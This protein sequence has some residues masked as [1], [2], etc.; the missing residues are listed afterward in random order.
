[1]NQD[2]EQA[3][4]IPQAEDIL[5]RLHSIDVNQFDIV[6]VT[7]ELKGN[8]Q[9]ISILTIPVTTILLGLFTLAGVLLFDSI[10]G[11][12][13]VAAGLLFFAGRILDQYEQQYRIRARHE[14][15]NRIQATEDEFGLIPHFK[16]FLPTKYRH[17]WQSLKKGN[18]MYV[19]QYIQALV[20]LQHKLDHEQFTKI[21]NMTYPELLVNS[22]QQDVA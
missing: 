3:I 22:E 12:F 5:A 10:I 15:M 21:W 6:A 16:H 17:L 14:V 7:N 20:L 9:W 11:S 1:M 4:A 18:Y 8:K 19:D 13:L 2:S